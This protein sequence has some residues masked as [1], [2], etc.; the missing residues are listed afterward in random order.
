MAH[1]SRPERDQP[2]NDDY[3][4]LEIPPQ[5]LSDVRSPKRDAEHLELARWLDAHPANRD[6]ADKTWVLDVIDRIV[7]LI[8]SARL[9]ENDR[10]ASLP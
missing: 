2:L 3:F 4:R 10:D 5:D 6:G 9:V 8:R 1:M 7:R